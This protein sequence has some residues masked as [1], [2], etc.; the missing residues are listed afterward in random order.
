MLRRVLFASPYGGIRQFSASKKLPYELSETFVSK[1]KHSDAPFGFNGLGELVYYR[2]YA[3]IKDSDGKR[4]NWV[5]TVQ[6][7]VNGTFQM[8]Y[9][10]MQSNTLPWNEQQYQIEAEDMFDR[11]FHMKFLPP[12]R[13][14]W[15]MG[16]GI[17]PLLSILL[18]IY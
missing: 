6:R 11:I 13:G 8:Q 2:T 12:G 5:D 15:A 10:W 14:L 4:E 17:Y 16:T 3:R 1:Y 18:T 7:V 9:E